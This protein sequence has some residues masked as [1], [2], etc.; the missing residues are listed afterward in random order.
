M[1]QHSELGQ[2]EGIIS[3]I[4]T[5]IRHYTPAATRDCVL[6]AADICEIT[7]CT[8]LEVTK[9][10]I[11]LERQQIIVRR[12]NNGVRRIQILERCIVQQGTL[13]ST[14]GGA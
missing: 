4:L 11:S 1:L 2:F 8:P 13:N 3:R 5:V 10:L 6:S 12:Q 14:E 9:A 7:G